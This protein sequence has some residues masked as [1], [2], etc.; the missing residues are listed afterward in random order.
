MG[1]QDLKV[2]GSSVSASKFEVFWGWGLSFGQISRIF[3][4][5]G[6]IKLLRFL[7]LKPQK[8]SKFEVRIRGVILR[9]FEES[10]KNLKNTPL[11]LTSNIEV[12]WGLKVKNLKSFMEPSSSKILKVCPKFNTQP[13]K[14]SNFEAEAENPR[15]LRSCLPT[16]TQPSEDS[17]CLYY[18][19][20]WS[21]HSLS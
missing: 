5:E 3:E 18:S 14:T 19:P 9:F 6:S 1:N 13:Q 20:W 15:I 16:L 12:F 4:D 11:I 7:S 17:F 10:S 2:W 8:T 21:I